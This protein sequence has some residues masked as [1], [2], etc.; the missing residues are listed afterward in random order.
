MNAPLFLYRLVRYPHIFMTQTTIF[1]FCFFL[2]IVSD[3]SATNKMVRNQCHGDSNQVKPCMATYIFLTNFTTNFIHYLRKTSF[4]MNSIEL[5]LPWII[6]YSFKYLQ[7]IWNDK[8][9]KIMSNKLKV[10][11]KDWVL[12]WYLCLFVSCRCRTEDTHT[13][14]KSYALNCDHTNR[15]M[16][17]LSQQLELS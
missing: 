3:L 13:H 2:T 12:P 10:D 1:F 6:K 9:L 7:Y 4:L 15:N 8:I 17:L 5:N 14:L 11:G 16:K